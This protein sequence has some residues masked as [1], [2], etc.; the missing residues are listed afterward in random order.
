MKNSLWEGVCWSRR[1]DLNLR[2]LPPQ[3][4]ALPDCATSRDTDDKLAVIVEHRKGARRGVAQNQRPIYL[5]T[6]MPSESL[7][8]WVVLARTYQAI[9]A[10][11]EA[12]ARSHD[13]TAAEFG[14]L[15]ALHHGGPALL[16]E[17]QK[18]ILVSSG[19]M[20]WL[21]DRLEK[22]GLVERTACPEDRRARYAKLTD[23]GR[24]FIAEIFPEHVDVIR[25][26][27]GGLPAHEQR[28]VTALLRTLGR[29]AADSDS[30][31][32]TE[33]HR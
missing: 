11:A 8:L 10:R 22:R 23:A 19:G 18:K 33:R 5:S 2:P 25:D 31:T 27:C 3:G 12:H 7:K 13:L 29:A 26:A 20:T 4:S 24:R 28:E 21:V 17:L 1:Q 14:V 16:G 32:S 15:E 30:N 6:E 9:A